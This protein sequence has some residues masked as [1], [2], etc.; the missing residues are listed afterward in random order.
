MGGWFI[1]GCTTLD[2]VMDQNILC[3]FDVIVSR[4]IDSMGWFHML[5][6]SCNSV[7][8]VIGQTQTLRLLL[9][10]DFFKQRLVGV[11]VCM[12]YLHIILHELKH[13]QTTR[14]PSST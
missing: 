14:R 9:T 3:F 12:Q 6:L 13:R 10:R 4:A 11:K 7:L 2:M 1:T 8:L 5:F